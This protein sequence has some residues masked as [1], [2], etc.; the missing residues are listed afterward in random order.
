MPAFRIENGC[1]LHP[2]GSLDYSGK[3]GRVGVAACQQCALA[4]VAYFH[5]DHAWESHGR[6]R[7]LGGVVSRGVNQRQGTL[8]GQ[9][10]SDALALLK[11]VKA[12]PLITLP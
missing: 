8:T 9:I 6:I 11:K 7:C 5:T 3:F 4:D 1:V 12:Y 2:V 10:L